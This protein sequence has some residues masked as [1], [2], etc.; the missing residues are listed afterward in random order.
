MSGTGEK[1]GRGEASASGDF[2]HQDQIMPI[3]GGDI[4]AEQR[5]DIPVHR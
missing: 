1:R 2:V 5:P 4:I 3:A